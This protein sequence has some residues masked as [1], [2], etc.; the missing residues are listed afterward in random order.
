MVL[1]LNR[2]VKNLTDSVSLL[3]ILLKGTT[4]LNRELRHAT[5][6]KAMIRHGKFHW[7]SCSFIHELPGVNNMY[8]T[9][10]VFSLTS[11]PSVPRVSEH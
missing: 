8:G 11:M 1:D 2:K 5:H 6:F 7:K 9:W 10:E 4:L 3:N